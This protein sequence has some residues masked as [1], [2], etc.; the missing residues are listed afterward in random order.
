MNEPIAKE[1]FMKCPICPDTR[2][3]LIDRQDVEKVY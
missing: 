1:R 2:L 3:V